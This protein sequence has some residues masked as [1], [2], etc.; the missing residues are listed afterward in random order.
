MYFLAVSFHYIHKENKYPFPGIYATPPERLN[1]QLDQLARHFDFISQDD[2]IDAVE[3]KKKLPERCCLI[4]FDDGLKSQ[5]ENAL[6]ILKKKGIPALFFVGTLPFRKRKVCQIH[7]VH[8]LRANLAPEEF[9]RRVG[10]HLK[11]IAGKS[12]D[13]FQVEGGAALKKY[14]YDNPNAAKL[15]FFLN[16]I[17]PISYKEK[18]VDRIFREVIDNEADFCEK[19][20]MSEKEISELAKLSFLGIHSDSH[21]LLSQL[22]EIE[23]VKE[24]KKS[25]TILSEILDISRIVSIAYPYGGPES[26]SPKV[27]KTCEDLGL[28]LGFTVE[29]AFNRSLQQPLLFARMD[30]ND[31][32]EG[33]YPAFDFKNNQVRIL[34]NITPSRNIYFKEKVPGDEF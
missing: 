17:M 21:R 10:G 30:T 20:Y 24:V 25:L 18:I 5:Y 1:K 31:V 8:W 26:I 27:V 29:R 15:K 23:T 2:L 7:K 9:L 22:S 13:D 32:L 34:G 28:K 12:M 33:K 19:F 14:R 6:P 3:S 16:Y 11:E 4:T